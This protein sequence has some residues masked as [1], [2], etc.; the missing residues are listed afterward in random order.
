MFNLL[1]A[2]LVCAGGLFGLWLGISAI[3]VAMMVAAVA[4][5]AALL[6]GILSPMGALAVATVLGILTAIGAKML[7]SG[8]PTPPSRALGA[9]FATFAA[10]VLAVGAT[11]S[12]LSTGLLANDIRASAAYRGVQPVGARLL[13]VWPSNTLAFP[14]PIVAESAPAAA[15]PRPIAWAT[16]DPFQGMA[17]RFLTG[18][19]RAAERASISFEVSGRVEGVRV[20]IGDS[21][22]KGDVLATLDR[23]ELQIAMREREAAMIEAQA[24]L[25][26]TTQ[27]LE[28]QRQ[29]LERAVVSEAAYEAALSAQGVAQSQFEVAQSLID[30]ARDNLEETTLEAPYS[31]TIAA[32]LVEPSQIVAA[33]EPVFEI[34]SDES[35]FEIEVTVPETIVS[36]IEIGSEHSATIFNGGEAQLDV[37]VAEVG[38]RGNDTTGFPVT[39]AITSPAPQVRANMSAEVAFSVE[40]RDVPAGVLA[41]PLSAVRIGPGDTREVLVFEPDTGT[42]RAA[43]VEV[44]N[45]E[46]EVALIAS[47]IREGDIVATRGVTT[48][49]DGDHVV[50]QGVGTARY[51]I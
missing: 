34:Q 45:A 43:T 28:R 39:L 12:A 49:Q 4:S 16:A 37:V 48:L 17:T 47:G 38:A 36:L 19:V 33:G 13:S 8:T 14:E 3:L 23:T 2:A 31:G 21:F 51:D 50:L 40:R 7:R 26:E 20:E 25:S 46:G 5:A 22:V 9:L 11:G 42:V 35:G 30:G 41:V 18:T 6:S 27:D 24:R 29:L 1:S 15:P 32:R 10:V 44:A